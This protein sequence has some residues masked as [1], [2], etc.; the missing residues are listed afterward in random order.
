MH[1]QVE[2]N[3]SSVPKK[4]GIPTRL[5]IKAWTFIL[6]TFQDKSAHNFVF[7]GTFFENGGKIYFLLVSAFFK[8]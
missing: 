2:N 3:F 7:A 6:I 4:M 8:K 5:K 1:L